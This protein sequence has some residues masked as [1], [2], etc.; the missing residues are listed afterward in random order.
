MKYSKVPESGPG[1]KS[2]IARSGNPA[3]TSFQLLTFD[4]GSQIFLSSATE[5]HLAHVF[6]WLTT[7]VSASF[8]TVNARHEPTLL[9]LHAFASAEPHRPGSVREVGLALA[10]ALETAARAGDADRDLH[11]PSRRLA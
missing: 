8:A 6:C 9:S 10:E 1:P 2:L 5:R 7:T 3:R 4:P 11:V